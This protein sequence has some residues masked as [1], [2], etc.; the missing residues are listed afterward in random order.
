[1]K[2]SLQKN[3]K[4]CLLWWSNRGSGGNFEGFITYITIPTKKNDNSS[5]LRKVYDFR[6][7]HNVGKKVLRP[8]EE[9]ERKY[10]L[11]EHS[12]YVKNWQI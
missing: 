8:T 10:T 12:E 3:F 9:T 4:Y 2:N 11:H 6:G 5:I 7:T 1:M